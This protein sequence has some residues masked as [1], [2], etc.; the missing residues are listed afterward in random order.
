MV[1][2]VTYAVEAAAIGA[3]FFVSFLFAPPGTW[4]VIRYISSI[5]IPDVVRFLARILGYFFLIFMLVGT[6]LGPLWWIPMQNETQQTI[7]FLHASGLAK[8]NTA[9]ELAN[10]QYV[11]AR[12]Q[13]KL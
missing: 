2:A 13:L 10:D 6:I 11:Q 7:D 3:W 1:T 4:F 9:S 12:H 8:I 5:D